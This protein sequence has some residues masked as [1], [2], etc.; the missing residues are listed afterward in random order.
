MN[1]QPKTLN[2]LL[3]DLK[4]AKAAVWEYVSS[5]ETTYLHLEVQDFRDDEWT[6][7]PATD[8]FAWLWVVPGAAGA[9]GW[10][11][12]R[13]TVNDFFVREGLTFVFYQDGDSAQW[14]V[15]DNANI[16]KEES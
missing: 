12:S 13:V 4:A 9:G 10:E 14:A 1:E 7:A 3:D 5:K 8:S 2:D 11:Y 6:G 16:R 15:F